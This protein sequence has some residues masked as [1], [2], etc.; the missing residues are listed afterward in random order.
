MERTVKPV[1][2]HYTIIVEITVKSVTFH[3]VEKPGTWCN[4]FYV[5]S[6]SNYKIVERGV[7]PVNFP[8]IQ[9]AS[10]KSYLT[11]IATYVVLVV[12]GVASRCLK[13]K[14]NLRF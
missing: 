11:N 6:T 2:F 13:P 4:T 3:P 5:P 9:L 14:L 8:S 12:I 7:S 10:R 1:T